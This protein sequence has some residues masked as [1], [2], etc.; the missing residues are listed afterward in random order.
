MASEF[1]EA[2]VDFEKAALAVQSCE[3][4]QAEVVVLSC[5]VAETDTLPA[6][7]ATG[8][9]AEVGAV[10]PIRRAAVVGI[11]AEVEEVAPIRRV[12]GSGMVAGI[13]TLPEA[14]EVDRVA[15]VATPARGGEAVRSGKAVEVGRA[16]AVASLAMVGTAA[17]S[18]SHAKADTL[19]AV[20]EADNPAEAARVVQNCRVAGVGFPVGAAVIAEVYLEES[21]VILAFSLGNCGWRK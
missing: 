3:A 5:T 16:G 6:A 15:A 1:P 18:Y 4:A 20:A 2:P 8:I 10:A 7:A 19:P 13:D 9:P 11:P 14:G 21:S 12:A 17:P